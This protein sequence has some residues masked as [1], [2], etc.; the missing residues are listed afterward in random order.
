[1]LMVFAVPS[2]WAQAWQ[3]TLA[4]LDSVMASFDPNG[5]GGV[6]T[7]NRKGET[8]YNRA[9]GLSNLE[10]RIAIDTLTVF[11]AGSVSKQFTAT[12]V[13]LLVLDGLLKLDDDVRNYVPELPVYGETITIRHL[14][15][16][17][18]GL[19]DWG[20]LASLGGWPRGTRVYQNDLALGYIAS[21]K[22]LNNKPGDEY[23]YSN[24]N[25]TLLTLIVERVSGMLL[26]EF[27]QKRLFAPL[28]MENTVWR[29]DFRKVV[30]HRAQAYQREGAHY[31]LNMPFENTYGHAALLTTTADLTLW[32]TSWKQSLL[33]GAQLRAMREERG[34]LNNGDTIGYAS[35]VEVG[36]YLGHASVTHSGSTAGYRAWLAYYP[37]DELS[38]AYLSNNGSKTLMEVANKVAAIFFGERTARTT[39]LDRAGEMD[40]S[41]WSKDELV[42]YE[43]RFYSEECQGG[44]RLLVEGDSLYAHWDNGD[45]ELLLPRE[46]GVFAYGATTVTFDVHKN[47]L[48]LGMVL[49]TPRARNVRFEKLR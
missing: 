30:G 29:D 39:N 34:V 7:I 17:T 4:R 47:G 9:I 44:I 22:S 33:G 12:S 15:N 23:I 1:M 11:E 43:G 8:V 25:Y 32:N 36:E 2:I 10:D 41:A 49:D 6:L 21:Q 20:V 40:R 26:P 3:D 31:V 37:D 16:H 27:A 14:L 19:K 5:P 46:K 18:S 35:A 13:L 28:G 42:G 38:V 24:S 48:I 45:R